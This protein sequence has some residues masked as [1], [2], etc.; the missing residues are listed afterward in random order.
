MA[1]ETGAGMRI[2]KLRHKIELQS[3][4]T[5]PDAVGHP[6]KTWTTHSTVWAW[7]RP[8]SGREVMNS[9]QPVGEI[10]HKVT[11][12]YNDTIVVTNRI[13]F[14]DTK[15]KVTRYFDINF[16]GNYDERN[17]FMEIMCKEKL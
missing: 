6:V 1:G 2:G 17:V 7:V 16:P 9:Q 10:T 3:Y 14:Y 4:T 15:R 13:K 11:I 8:M 5:T 12:R